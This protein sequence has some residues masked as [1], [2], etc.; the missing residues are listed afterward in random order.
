M[1]VAVQP[2]FANSAA[3]T[4]DS[5]ERPGWNG[6]VMVPKF[7]R[8]PADWLAPMPMAR[9][10]CSRLSPIMRAAPAAAVIAPMVAVE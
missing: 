10:V 5:A 6:L 7:S 1:G 4:P 2:I 9:R 8:R 3:T